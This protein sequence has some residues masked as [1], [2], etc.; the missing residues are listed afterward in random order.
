MDSS[1]ITF[2]ILTVSD[3]C[4][5]N[6]ANDLSGDALEQIITKSESF[7]GK[8][9]LRKLVPD[10]VNLIK[11]A[12]INIC[13]YTKP[14][15]I[16]TTGGTGF[17][18]RDVTPEATK[19]ILD[20]E[21]PGLTV[22]MLQESLKITS[23]AMLSR[24]DLFVV[25]EK[26]TLI[27]NLPGS[28]KGSSEC[29]GIIKSA[30]PHAVHL[31]RDDQKN[32]KLVHRQVQDSR[33]SSSVA[34]HHVNRVDHFPTHTCSHS[35]EA[36]PEDS[37]LGDHFDRPLAH[38]PR[39]SA[40]TAIS[41]EEA[42]E[43]VLKE[44]KVKSTKILPFL[45]CA[46]RILAEDVHAKDPLPPFPASIK[47]GY[48]VIAED[49]AGV[50]QVVGGS[51]AG[52]G[53][54]PGQCV[55]I[56][57][58]APVPPGANAVVQVE[59][60]KLIKETDEGNTELEIEILTTPKVEQDIRP[61]GCDISKGEKVLPSGIQL[62]Y[63]ELG[64]LAMVG[65]TRVSVYQLPLVG[66]LSTGNELVNPEVEELVPGKI[67]DSNKTLLSSL[68]KQSGFP[69]VDLGIATDTVESLVN[70][71]SEGLKSCDVIISSGGVS[72]GDKDML[73]PVLKKHFGATIHFGRVLIIKPG[74]PT[75][76]VTLESDGVKKLIFALPGN[77]VSAAVTCNVFAIPA[78]RKLA[79]HS[80]TRQTIIKAKMAHQ[81]QLD[82][83]PEF[84]RA[85]LQWT[86]LEGLSVPLAYSTGNQISSKLLNM[87]SA[88]ALI[89]L[90]KQTKDKTFVQEGE[91]VDCIII[92][93]V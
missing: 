3:S 46:G 11:E 85:I 77:P 22:A 12:L 90:P 54:L 10:D 2:A 58:G 32:V 83:R 76:F 92:G 88:Q 30:I 55:R 67:R 25:S 39:K 64:I 7:F 82:P 78:L 36:S 21:A 18:T 75:T 5:A 44:A 48:A 17:S 33:S 19:S 23:M 65:V 8:V 16:L 13:E 62:N 81:I 69:T 9:L 27:A 56:N 28:T 42:I 57:T 38:R 61:I 6:Y 74:L 80:K 40:F 29:F 51:T 87:V 45:D 37:H 63:S 93:D 73:K 26:Q 68:I 53:V 59:D 1:T 34:N 71:L 31:L 14:D 66:L 24:S 41:V 15:V 60:T 43:I 70:K 86:N 79:G 89:K 49:G 47:D 20:K 35:I 50:R 84:Q 72:M 52:S 4:Y 91:I